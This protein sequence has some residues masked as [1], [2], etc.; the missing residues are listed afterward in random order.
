MEQRIFQFRPHLAI[1]YQIQAPKYD[2]RHL[3][4]VMSGFNIP[5]PTIYDF[6]MLAHC[7]SA[8]LWI[9]DD[10]DGLPAY[11]LCRDMSFEFE[12]GVSTLI[13]AVRNSVKPTHVSILGASKGGT[14]SLYFGIKHKIKNII[15]A[16]PQF[17]IGRYVATGYW[18]DVGKA[19]M[20]N[21]NEENQYFLDNYLPY[22]LSQDRC[23]ERNIY[24]FT[25][26]QD[27]QFK[28]EVEP[29]LHLLE[30]YS[31]FNLIETRSAY[32]TEHTQVTAYNLNLIL[33]LI[34]Q[35]EDGIAPV[36]GQI[37]NGSQW[38]Q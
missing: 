3:L 31:R 11:Y 36:W 7:R 35:F 28:T 17:S 24:L 8:I 27:K 26:P 1:R 38:S 15:T 25:S 13:E 33:A 37:R 4:I 18:Q 2:C 9:K 14:A 34:Y 23:L 12:E 30:K 16:V 20:G 10:V 19:M 6:S 5:D 22:A 21:V 29:N 32:V